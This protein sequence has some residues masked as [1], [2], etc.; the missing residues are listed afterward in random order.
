MTHYIIHVN[1]YIICIYKKKF[2]GSKIEKKPQINC[3]FQDRQAR[4]C[5]IAGFFKYVE[6]IQA[7]E[8]FES[9]FS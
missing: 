2:F 1:Y 4:Q 3:F 6:F 9:M 8:K 5:S 7:T